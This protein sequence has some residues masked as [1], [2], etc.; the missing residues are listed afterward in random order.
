MI[1]SGPRSRN[2]ATNSLFG[3]FFLTMFGWALLHVW[4]IY[5]H[6]GVLLHTLFAVPGLVLAGVTLYRYRRHWPIGNGSFFKQKKQGLNLQWDF[7]AISSYL[8]LVAVGVGIALLVTGGSVF[9]V[10][11]V[12]TGIVLVPWA[13]ISVCRNHFFFSS[14]MLAVGALL[15]S[16]LLSGPVHPLYYA[17]ASWALLAIA[18]TTVLSVVL[19]HG[20]RLDRMPVSGYSAVASTSP[21]DS[22][23]A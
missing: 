1:K 22:T 4:G 9:L 13:N 12:A 5:A 23:P 10:V 20:D 2:L 19:T 16:A 6:A 17:L 18:C 15:G 21:V 11:L 14:A 3:A 8:L 7:R